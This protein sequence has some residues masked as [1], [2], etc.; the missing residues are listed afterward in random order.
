MIIKSISYENKNFTKVVHLIV[1]VLIVLTDV[2]VRL[3]I[4]FQVFVT[5]L[6]LNVIMVGYYFLF[7]YDPLKYSTN[8]ERRELL[9]SCVNNSS[10]E[11]SQNFSKLLL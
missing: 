4:D 3:V 7:N 9:S 10:R 11:K 8:I 5:V 6:E 1:M 2:H